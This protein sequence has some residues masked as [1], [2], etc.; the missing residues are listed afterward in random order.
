MCPSVVFT[1]RCSCG[2]LEALSVEQ[3][4]SDLPTGWNRG[5]TQSL[6]SSQWFP[7]TVISRFTQTSH[8]A[9][10]Y[11]DGWSFRNKSCP[12]AYGGLV[13]LELLFA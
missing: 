8:E 13:L 11:L 6:H 9:G 1:L 10:I 5:P 7:A 4:H 2:G 3:T 12:G